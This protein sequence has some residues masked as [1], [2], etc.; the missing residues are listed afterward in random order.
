M[1]TTTW[2]AR[3]TW[4][5]EVPRPADATGLLQMPST[6]DLAAPL[7]VD[8]LPAV[9]ALSA[10]H[11]TA[12]GIRPT[13]RVVVALNNDGVGVGAHLALAAAQAA[14][15]AVSAGP[16]GRMRLLRALEGSR[17]TALVI[18]PTGA[19]D[20]LARLHIEFLVD[21]LDLGIERI[22][23]VGEIP[24]PGSER[25]LA[26]DFGA[27]VGAV[28]CD[29]YFGVAVGHRAGT[30]LVADPEHVVAAPLADD[31]VTTP[32]RGPYELVL[33]PVWSAALGGAHLRTGWVGVAG[34]E[35]AGALPWPTA[36]VGDRVLARGRWL[37][38][39]AVAAA[40]RLI[41]GIEAWSLELRRDGTLDKVQ[42]R[43]AFNRPSLTQNKMWAG[44]IR[45]ALDALTPVDIEVEVVDD[46]ATVGDR[47][48]DHRGH[49]LGLD[50]TAVKPG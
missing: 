49:H 13:D 5:G 7:A 34:D 39:Q 14:E 11:L 22:V 33:R 25:Q 3:E 2:A 30:T 12:A 46:P 19:M 37:S 42:L 36:T 24:S 15:A 9:V 35:T 6:G 16:R 41:D 48:V 1:T 47:L 29:P 21:P 8:E 26:M 40:L 20:L 10:R 27:E 44:R 32:E 31:V 4:S 50:R 38:V 28:L 45:A 43:V 18:T 17:A 23:L